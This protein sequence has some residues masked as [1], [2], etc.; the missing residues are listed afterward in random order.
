M[1]CPKCGFVDKSIEVPELSRK[2][3]IL[4]ECKKCQAKIFCIPSQKRKEYSQIAT[5]QGGEEREEY[6]VG[7]YLKH[8]QGHSS[9]KRPASS[10]IDRD[11]FDEKGDLLYHWEIKERSNTINAYR[12]TQFPYAKIDEAKR[13]IKETEKPVFIVLKFA[14]CWTRI[15]IDPNKQ[16]K[17]GKVPFAPRY[18]PWQR[19]KDR[20]IPVQLPVEELE[21]LK[22][23]EE[24]QEEFEI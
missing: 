10:D 3:I 22:I 20:Q 11:V 2:K 15:K 24:C 12:E 16:Y 6:L 1:I 13:L 7:I 23:K 4:G 9:K 18:R 17:K 21:V 19:S 5:V 8:K 14:D